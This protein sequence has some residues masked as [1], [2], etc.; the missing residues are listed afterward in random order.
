[1][2]KV[3]KCAGRCRSAKP[4]ERFRMIGSYRD[5]VYRHKVCNDC[6]NE[7]R[8][9]KYKRSRR[10]IFFDDGKK[11][12]CTSRNS[13]GEIKTLDNFLFSVS[14]KYERY[15]SLC[16]DC[17]KKNR[18][19]N[20]EDPEFLDSKRAKERGYYSNTKANHIELKS[21]EDCGCKWCERRTKQR[22]YLKTPRGKASRRRAHMRRRLRESMA[23]D[24][25]SM[26]LS[27]CEKI[28]SA[29]YC[30][31][32]GLEFTEE[33]KSR[34]RGSLVSIAHAIPISREGTL[35]STRN[36]FPQC[37]SRINNCQNTQYNK[38]LGE[39]IPPRDL[40]A[41]VAD[42]IAWGVEIPN[43]LKLAMKR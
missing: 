14:G 9:K 32:C 36:C 35:H 20:C 2:G 41:V 37:A 40:D 27:A 22:A 13:C 18:E 3:K 30:I 23:E 4:I 28:Y 29:P 21:G 17:N 10:V 15:S 8:R 7:Q 24:D 43:E 33:E 31:T 12:M 26:T 5:K 42:L 25:G 38:I 6:Y 34:T 16:R 11:K 1:M 39:W 19:S